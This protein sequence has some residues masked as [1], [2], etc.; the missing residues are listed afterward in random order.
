[1]KSIG[2]TLIALTLIFV[3]TACTVLTPNATPLPTTQNEETQISAGFTDDEEVPFIIL[4]PSGEQLAVTQ[5][6]NSKEKTG[7]VWTSPEGNSIV[8]FS[9]KDGSPKGAVVGDDIL[10]YSNF[11]GNTIDITILHPDGTS[12]VFT[13]LEID[14]RLINKIKPISSSSYNLVSFSN[15]NSRL[16]ILD[17]GLW[18]FMDYAWITI[19]TATCLTTFMMG[20]GAGGAGAGPAGATAGAIATFATLASICAGVIVS[21]IIKAAEIH[22]IDSTPLKAAVFIK[23]LDDCKKRGL[24]VLQRKVASVKTG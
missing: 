10:L 21:V 4:H 18:D 13:N 6:V 20:T 8:I 3:I 16:Q 1:M 23:N 5:D 9:D 12:E 15:K 14:K 7:V 2:K 24:L 17:E 22:N 19:G 11:N